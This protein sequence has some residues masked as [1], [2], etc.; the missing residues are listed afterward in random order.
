MLASHYRQRSGATA[1]IDG[2]VHV[3]DGPLDQRAQLIGLSLDRRRKRG[4]KLLGSW[5]LT[6]RRSVC[7]RSLT[8]HTVSVCYR[9]LFCVKMRW[10][11]NTARPRT[12]TMVRL[13]IRSHWL[14]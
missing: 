4:Q 14:E 3:R 9:R 1:H 5:P 6:R 10:S 7:V 11:A 8:W 12:W 2:L 13:V